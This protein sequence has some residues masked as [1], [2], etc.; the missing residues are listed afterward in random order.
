MVRNPVL[1][2]KF[3][4]FV[5]CVNG[6]ITQTG[7]IQSALEGVDFVVFTQGT[8]GDPTA[9]EQVDYGAVRNVL[10][11]LKGAR[12]RLALMSTIGATDR[13]G[14]H[15]WKR[16]GERLVRA[17]GLDYTIVRPGWFDYNSTQTGHAAR[18]HAIDRNTS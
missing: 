17:S 2:K 1:G 5:E 18:R 7:D 10:M 3:P 11:G 16:R 14:S 13:K 8:Y 6:N 4:E 9:A 12:V 15:D